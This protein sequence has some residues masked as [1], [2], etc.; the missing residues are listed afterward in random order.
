MLKKIAGGAACL[1][2]VSVDM[3]C[4]ALPTHTVARTGDS[5]MGGGAIAAIIIGCVLLVAVVVVVVVMRKKHAADTERGNGPA[6]A[7]LHTCVQ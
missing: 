1:P 7:C 6:A 3:S 5:A 4:M 2:Q